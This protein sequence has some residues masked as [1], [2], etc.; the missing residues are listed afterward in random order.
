MGRLWIQSVVLQPTN[1]AEAVGQ[2]GS[3]RESIKYF[4]VNAD[5]SMTTPVYRMQPHTAAHRGKL[6]AGSDCVTSKFHSKTP[7]KSKLNLRLA[8]GRKYP[9]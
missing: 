6:V 7:Q 2:T 5:A 1:K 4:E 8:V 9:D 3:Y